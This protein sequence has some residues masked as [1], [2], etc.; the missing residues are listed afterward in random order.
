MR[1]TCNCVHF[2]RAR[3]QDVR[4][5]V[6]IEISLLQRLHHPHIIHLEDSFENAAEM[7]LLTEFL[8]GGELFER[9]AS[10]EFNLT[11]AECVQFVRQICEGVKYIH[12]QVSLF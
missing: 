8:S 9:V 2:V 12:E 6:R 11:E 4:D 7:V 5:K 3:R 10:E 1:L